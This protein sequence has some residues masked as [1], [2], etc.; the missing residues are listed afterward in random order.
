LVQK[1]RTPMSLCIAG[2]KSIRSLLVAQLLGFVW[3]GSSQADPTVSLKAVKKNGVSITPTNNVTNT[4]AGDVYECEAYVT[5]FEGLIDLYNGYNV[6]IAGRTGVDSAATDG[7]GCG[8][9]LPVGWDAPLDPIPCL[10]DLDCTEHAPYS[11][12]RAAESN[13]TCVATDHH[14]EQGAFATTNRP[15]FI[16]TGYALIG[17]VGTQALDYG[18][19]FIANDFEPI[20]FY[21][22]LYAATLKLKVQ[23]G[24]SGTFTFGFVEGD[25]FLI[26]PVPP[27]PNTLPLRGVP[28]TIQVNG[29]CPIKIISTVPPPC[30]IDARYPNDPAN[31]ATRYGFESIT[32]TYSR[33]PGSISIPDFQVTTVPF[34]LGIPEICDIEQHGPVVKLTFCHPIPSTR[35]TCVNSLFGEQDIACIGALGADTDANKLSETTDTL[36]LIDALADNPLALQ[37]W[38]TDLDRSGAFTPIDIFASIDLLNGAGALNAF[39]NLTLVACPTIGFPR[40]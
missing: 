7:N 38:Q 10:T 20:D 24:A 33:D 39:N 3:A 16:L 32:I 23:S 1:E 40:P 22:P 28:L 19:G 36:A 29:E 37:I 4:V 15:D 12:C 2:W 9:V 18:Y 25:S 17:G 6:T 34:A 27:Q 8:L 31:Q 5:E 13:G 26:V 11:I 14:P 35:W 21:K 30:A